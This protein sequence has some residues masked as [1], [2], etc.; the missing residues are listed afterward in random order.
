MKGSVLVFFLVVLAI[1]AGCDYEEVVEI[2][3]VYPAPGD[4]V[5]IEVSHI[6]N[7]WTVKIQE[8]PGA[9]D[10][11]NIEINV[12]CCIAGNIIGISPPFGKVIG[13]TIIWEVD[14]SFT[15]GDFSFLL[16]DV[17]Y[18]NVVPGGIIVVVKAGRNY[19]AVG[20]D[21]PGC[22]DQGVI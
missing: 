3:V 2:S 14:D 11:S 21:G 17:G 18:Y 9:Q 19:Q 6:G 12:S 8:L 20:F 10:V 16:S 7:T 15:S 5:S 13:T 4:I 1:M 22:H